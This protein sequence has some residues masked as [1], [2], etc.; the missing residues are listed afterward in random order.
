M[1]LQHAANGACARALIML[2]P[3]S[4]R[5]YST[6]FTSL[7][8]PNLF[9]SSCRKMRK[10]DPF[11]SLTKRPS[12]ASQLPPGENPRSSFEDISVGTERRRKSRSRLPVDEEEDS[13]G[14]QADDEPLAETRVRTGLANVDIRRR[15]AIISA[16]R[17]SLIE[18]DEGRRHSMLV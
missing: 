2:S 5:A 9:L 4:T 1:H 3:N 10:P 17:R 18:D 14:A 15:S 16:S 11:P 13:D 12:S 7:P 8:V 6:S